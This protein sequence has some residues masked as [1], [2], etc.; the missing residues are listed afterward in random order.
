MSVGIPGFGLGGLFFVLSALVAPLLELPRTLRGESSA[1]VWREIGRNVLLSLLIIVAVDFALRVALLVVW[2][3]GGGSLDSVTEPV[4]LPVAP[5]G[6]TGGL[7]IALLVT[8]KA[9]QLA[10][11][12]LDLLAARRAR[13]ARRIR[14]GA[15]CPC[16]AD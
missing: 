11:G 8:A 12:Y 10:L 14:H 16:C 9:A 6:A 4:V 15:S 2:L 3:A 1:A 5:I 13:R 7:L